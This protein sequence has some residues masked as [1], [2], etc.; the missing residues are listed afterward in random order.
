MLHIVTVHFRTP[1]WI[2]PQARRL[3]QFAPPGTQRWAILD[4]IAPEYAASFDHVVEFEENHARRL[5]EMARRVSE[6]ADPSD[7]LLF[8]DGDAFPLRDL[9]PLVDA[10]D[11]VPLI[12]VRRD[13]NLGDPQPHPSFCLTTVKFWNDVGGDWKLGYRW[14]NRNGEM[15][16]DVG[17]NLLEALLERGIEWEPLLRCNSFD[18]H[19][20][21]FGVYGNADWGPV[22]YHHG[23]GFRERRGRAD[24]AP[25]DQPPNRILASLGARI[26]PFG[27]LHEAM[28]ARKQAAWEATTGS[29]Q[30]RNAAEV[31][32]DLCADDD[33]YRRFVS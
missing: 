6:V 3:D 29:T 21:W 28:R 32:A 4:G 12:A 5:N 26:P 16:T 17:A 9:A 20:V 23:A 7:A 33:F 25:A 10:L 8:L 31:F 22:V 11:D 30:D 27:R 18:L 1:E 14:R 24:G 15:V 2:S 13:E 19:P